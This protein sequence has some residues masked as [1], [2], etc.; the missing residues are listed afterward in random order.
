MPWW[1]LLMIVALTWCLWAFATVFQ[2]AASEATKK[3]P[4]GK[5]GGVSLLP[6][7][8]LFPLA[9]FGIAKLADTFVTSWGTRVIGTSHILLALLFLISIARD[10]YRLRCLPRPE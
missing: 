6:V 5:R 4:R 1:L 3:V 2:R 8:P 7:I 9:F 10:W